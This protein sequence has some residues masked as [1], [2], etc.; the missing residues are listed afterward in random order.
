MRELVAAFPTAVSHPFHVS[1]A[2]APMEQHEQQH[3][4]ASVKVGWGSSSAAVAAV[5]ADGSVACLLDWT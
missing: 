2:S 1:M 5:G 4:P 3:L